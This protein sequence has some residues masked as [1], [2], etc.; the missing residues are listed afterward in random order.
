M[1]DANPA[2][3]KRKSDDKIQGNAAKPKSNAKPKPV[4][5]GPSKLVSKVTR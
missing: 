1:A 3:G 5:V 2:Q 4:K